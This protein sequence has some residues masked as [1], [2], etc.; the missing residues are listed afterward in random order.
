MRSWI[1]GVSLGLLATT[2]TANAAGKLY[3]NGIEVPPQAILGKEFV[4]VNMKVDEN[5]DIRIDA[6][7]YKIAVSNPEGQV[8]QDPIEDGV[9]WLVTQDNNSSGHKIEV[10]VN[11]QRTKLISSGDEQ[12]ILDLAPYL[13]RGRNNVVINALPGSAPGGGD[14][15]IYMGKGSNDSGT[16]VM[17]K[18]DVVYARRASDSPSGGSRSFTITIP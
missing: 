8:E 15:M 13:K 2:T 3:I 9:Y 10:L 14:L 12:V 16:V 5:G 17:K 1:I 7:R 6:P 4:E 11:D 18:P